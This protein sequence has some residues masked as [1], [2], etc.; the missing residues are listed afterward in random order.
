MDSNVF[1]I[2]EFYICIFLSRNIGIEDDDL[3]NSEIIS[4]PL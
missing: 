3:I 4:I 1:L 2:E